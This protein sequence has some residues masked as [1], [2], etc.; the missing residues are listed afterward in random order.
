MNLTMA[1]LYVLFFHWV[2]D[3]ICQSRWMADNK[4]K[5]TYA[6]TIHVLTYMTVMLLSQEAL[7]VTSSNT[8]QVQKAVWTYVLINGV[9]H[10]MTDFITSQFTHHFAEKKE[11]YK[12]FSTVGLDQLIHQFCLISTIFYL[13]C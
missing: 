10:W 4:N 11:W 1:I 3:F 13:N 9:L 7:A 12:F 8:F 2:G 5:S 6:L